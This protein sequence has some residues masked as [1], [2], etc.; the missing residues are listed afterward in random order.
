MPL[1]PPVKT[2]LFGLFCALL[3]SGSAAPG[4]PP[5]LTGDC[6]VH[7]PSTIVKCK[8]TY[9]LFATGPGGVS[10]YSSD[11]LEWH[12]GPP[13]FKTLPDWVT[14]AVPRN[15][16][17]IW[18]PDIVR[19]GKR[20]RLY[21]SV[22]TFGRNRSVIGLATNAT[23]DPADPDFEW[24]DE[25][26]VVQ[27]VETDSYNCIDPCPFVDGK[28]MWLAFG[29]F[30]SGIKLVQLDPATGKR[31]SPDSPVL[32][33]ATH[34]PSTAIEA[35]YLYR[36]GGY[37]YLFVNWDLCCRGVNSTY[38]IRVGRSRSVTGPYV[39]RDGMAMMQ[40]GGTLFLG[41]SGTKIGPG[42]IGILRDGGKEWF[43]CHYYDG[44]A[45]GRPTLDIQPLTWS[46]DGW[47]QS[48]ATNPQ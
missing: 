14:T 9:W 2:L 4:D 10:R 25:G 17:A 3:A 42:C 37:Y 46:A 45:N 18:A 22:S 27:S 47:P 43:S 19:Q 7:D 38:N 24:K 40:G 23:L 13:V 36:R 28:R 20:Y 11:R 30:W 12:T 16:G 8:Q 21:Y 35:S 48:T 26:S 29:S 32:S 41:T 44:N 39:D 5:I 34:P 33:L 6:Y 1:K 31:L 15:R